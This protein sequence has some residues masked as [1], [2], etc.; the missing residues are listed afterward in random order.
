MRRISFSFSMLPGVVALA[1]TVAG[2]GACGGALTAPGSFP[3]KTPTTP[4]P[5]STATNPAVVATTLYLCSDTAGLQEYAANANGNV[6]IEAYVGAIECLGATQDAAG[7]IYEVYSEAAIY[8]GLPTSEGVIGVV[9]EYAPGT[10]TALRSILLG[11]YVYGAAMAVDK[12]GNIYV[13]ET[14][15][16]IVEFGPGQSGSATPIR[17]IS[18]P[19][20]PAGV[21]GLT[22][23]GAG[24]FYALYTLSSSSTTGVT[25]SVVMYPA[26]SS[27]TVTPTVV[28]PPAYYAHGIAFDAAG[29]LYISQYGSAIPS[30]IY[31]FAPGSTSSSTPIRSITGT[32]TEFPA[33]PSG[34]WAPIAVDAGG[35]IFVSSIMAD[36]PGAILV[37]SST[38]TGN[39]A[40]ASTISSVGMGYPVGMYLR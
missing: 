27:G 36:T 15:G 30:G 19:T 37:F 18:P 6:N 31:V 1:A 23:D 33:T 24:N 5:I 9:S 13:L 28:I 32:A 20:A 14:S 26:A 21:L 39:V 29:N 17:T 10:S 11:S 22:L 3:V 4:V 38:A 16:T 35:N 8:L 34:V 12:S 25:T 7:N 40:P 2:L